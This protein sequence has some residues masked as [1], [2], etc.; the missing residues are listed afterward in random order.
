ME[1]VG[2]G[3]NVLAFIIIGLKSAQVVYETYSS[4]KDSPKTL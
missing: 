3:A 4:I 1:A 2:A